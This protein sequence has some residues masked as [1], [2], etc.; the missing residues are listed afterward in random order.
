[1]NHLTKKILCGAL[2]LAVAVALAACGTNPDTTPGT[3]SNDH[4]H[5][6]TGPWIADANSHWK[7]CELCQEPAVSQEHTLDDLSECSVCNSEILEFDGFV[8]IYTYDE[9]DNIIRMAD[10]DEEGQV[11]DEYVYEN[12]YDADG[13]IIKITEYMFGD[14]FGISEYAVRDGESM[15][16]KFTGFD[17]DDGTKFVNEYDDYGNVILLVTYDENGNELLRS[18]SEFAQDEEG[19]WYESACIEAYDDG[20]KME[21]TYDFCESILSRVIYD[22]DGTV[23][24]NETWEYTYMDNGFVATEKAYLDGVLVTES[25]YQIMEDD[26]ITY[27]YPATVTTYYEDGTYGVCTYN[28]YDELISEHFYDSDGNVI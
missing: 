16:V 21:M 8:S 28:E 2:S 1:M 15:V 12:E 26:D 24:S 4:T 3:D 25:I 20:T 19:Q 17:A 10:Y 18:E 5:V 22:V 23:T 9:H 11:S 13:H 7:Q 14:L 27:S 6:A